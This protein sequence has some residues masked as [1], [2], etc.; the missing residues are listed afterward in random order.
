MPLSEAGKNALWK[1]FRL[2]I[3]AIPVLAGL[4]SAVFAVPLSLVE[5]WGYADSFWTLMAEICGVRGINIAPLEVSLHTH[6]HTHTTRGSQTHTHAPNSC[7]SLPV[8]LACPC[9]LPSS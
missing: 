7:G 1:L 8:P 5:G 9:P 3:V 6:T 4:I 2:L